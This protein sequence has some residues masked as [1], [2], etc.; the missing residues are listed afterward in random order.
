MSY[1]SICRLMLIQLKFFT[2][3]FSSSKS[4]VQQEPVVEPLVVGRTELIVKEGS[5]VKERVSVTRIV[6]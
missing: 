2:F 4:D 5:V 1:A 3:T 6:S